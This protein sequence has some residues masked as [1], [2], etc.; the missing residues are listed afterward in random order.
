M[1]SPG[2]ALVTGVG[3]QDGTYLARLL[4]D[5][6]VPVLGTRTPGSG[7]NP[8]L[9]DLSSI[10][11][12]ARDSDGFADLLERHRPAR[13]FHLAAIS[14]VGR[15]WQQPRLVHEVNGMAVL[16][17][18]EALVAFRQRHD[19]A[20]RLFHASSAEVFGA[21]DDR[22]RSE[23]DAHWP[24]NP[25]GVSK[26]WAHQLVNSYR[27]AHGLFAVNGILYN[28]ESPLRGSGFVTGKITRAAAEI[29]RGRADHVSLGNMAVSRD[30]SHAA[31]V[32]R[33]IAA[34]LER[35]EPEDFVLASGV[36]HSLA[37]LLRV[38]FE[39]A[40]V[41]E[42]ASRV[43]IDPAFFR[44]V[45]GPSPLGDATKARELLGWAPTRTFEEMVAEMVAVD[46]LRIDSGVEHSPTHLTW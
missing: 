32:V 30:W 23:R 8:Y 20:P 15:S 1:S 46:L 2:L 31:D 34:M 7:P 19:W 13:V 21:L 18:L 22:P 10:E 45:D 9:P 38:A 12:D 33:G 5:R 3:G 27:E 28:H 41:S 14:S 16:G 40:G 26:S 35:D 11:W 4:L 6:G 17:I 37:D 39:A 42:P 36:G 25:Y 44:P 43:R 29:A 24:R